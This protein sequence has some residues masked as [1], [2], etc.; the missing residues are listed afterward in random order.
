LAW[1]V[2][3]VINVATS[4]PSNVTAEPRTG[5]PAGPSPEPESA[6]SSDLHRA[7]Q[8]AVKAAH[9]GALSQRIEQ[10]LVRT[11][12][13][14]LEAYVQ[15][16][17]AQYEQLMVSLGGRLK[18]TIG[19]EQIE[20]FWKPRGATFPWSPIE[21]HS[22]TVGEIRRDSDGNIP[23]PSS[24][25]GT[26]Q[27]VESAFDFGVSTQALAS[28]TARVIAFP[29]TDCSKRKMDVN[30]VLGWDESR[31][32]EIPLWMSILHAHGEPMGP[33]IL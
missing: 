8:S 12:A 20:Q 19:R 23:M 21:E 17:W 9:T 4:P 32:R 18:S 6:S 31:K 15:P 10:E 28:G 11:G 25:D 14:L 24:S 3:L 16:D 29:V 2:F 26:T 27:L 13:E 5:A 1:G 22:I 30:I 7:F 33:A